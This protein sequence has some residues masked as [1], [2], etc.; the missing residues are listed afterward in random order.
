MAKFGFVHNLFFKQSHSGP[1]YKILFQTKP[2]SG[3]V[4]NF[5]SCKCF[6]QNGKFKM[7]GYKDM[8]GSFDDLGLTALVFR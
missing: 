6:V 4:Q 3:F 2:F 5:I 7:F 8:L 1:L